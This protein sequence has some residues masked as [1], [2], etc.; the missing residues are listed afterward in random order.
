MCILPCPLTSAKGVSLGLM[1]ASSSQ[2]ISTLWG[3]RLMHVSNLL[4]IVKGGCVVLSYDWTSV[5]SSGCLKRPSLSLLESLLKEVCIHPCCTAILVFVSQGLKKA[6][7]PKNLVLQL[8][9]FMFLSLTWSFSWGGLYS[10]YSL[11]TAISR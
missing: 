4:L 3:F 5:S 11:S 9:K 8:L 7:K 10:P 1:I 2:D 6:F